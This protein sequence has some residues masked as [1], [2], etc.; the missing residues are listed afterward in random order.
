MQSYTQEFWEESPQEERQE[1][2]SFL[3]LLPLFLSV[4]GVKDNPPAPPTPPKRKAKRRKLALV[5]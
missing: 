3:R 1:L 4:R 5:S 2:R